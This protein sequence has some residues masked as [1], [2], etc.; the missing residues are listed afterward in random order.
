MNKNWVVV[1]SSNG[2]KIFEATKGDK[3]LVCLE[4]L[5]HPEGRM[6]VSELETDRPGATRGGSSVSMMRGHSDLKEASD[7]LFA[8]KVLDYLDLKRKEHKFE[9]VFLVSEPAFES[10]LS[11]HMPHALEKVVEETIHKNYYN[12][13]TSDI[14]ERLKDKILYSFPV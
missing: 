7:E 14:F 10:Y 3:G 1:M 11:K 12:L 5:D 6:K 2:A 9:R 4:V 13:E 8:K